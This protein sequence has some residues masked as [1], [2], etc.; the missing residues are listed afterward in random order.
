MSHLEGESR[1]QGSLLPAVLDDYVAAEHPVRVIDAFVESLDLGA[2]GFSRVVAAATG[3]PGYAPGSLL[4]VYVYG[5][6]NQVRSS[7]RLAR[8]CERN[9]EV[10]WLLRRL[11][12]RFK[13]IADFRRD[14]PQAIVA[15]C[16]AFTR[17]CRELGL[18]SAQ[19]VAVDGTKVGAVASRKRVMT[20][21]RV[22]QEQ[23]RVEARIAAY[24]QA[25]DEADEEEA[26]PSA[27]P[28]DV[29][30][31]LEAL[32]S[33]RSELQALASQMAD[34]GLGQ[35]VEGEPDAKLM[36]GAHGHLT[37]YNAQI[38]V[39]EKHHLIAASEVTNECND[40][41]QLL[42]MGEAAKASL[43]VER[44]EVVADTGYANGEQGRAC[45]E[46]GITACVPRPTVVN[47]RGDYFT[48]ERFSY[49]AESDSYRCPAGETLPRRRTSR[50]QQ[51]Y[52][53]WSKACGECA[54]KGQCTDRKQRVIV[55]SFFEPDVEAMNE[56]A[57]SDPKRMCLRH[58]L[59]EH[60]IGTMKWLMG[61]PR[62]LVR[63]L[64]KVR[65]EFGLVVLG[66]NL[67]RVIA[68]LGVR[69]VLQRLA[70]WRAGALNPAP[71]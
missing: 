65:G 35:V 38:A 26:E 28:Q 43:G 68:V 50:T 5:Y 64:G 27:A 34:E 17:F 31:A 32:K 24:L 52:Q 57:K 11:T 4:K 58:S 71:A 23:T 22:E 56:R 49:D 16:R 69:T 13:T 70:D 67:K 51:Q 41:R 20:P 44:L 29:R 6:L 40:H 8:E 30:A 39:D 63:G 7:R 48:R 36:R 2:L 12:P 62:F 33:R 46:R 54:L 18:F 15:V 55:R 59:A 60:P 42:P 21:K 9:V 61:V 14:H 1:D 66:Y 3:R 45:A 47:P 10:M 53:Y 37:G 25:M 19:L